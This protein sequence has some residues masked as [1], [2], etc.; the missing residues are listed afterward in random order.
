MVSIIIPIYNTKDYL[1]RCI[2]SVV[3]QSYSDIE[4]ILVNDGSTDNCL[5]ICEKWAKR[6][7]RIKII[8]QENRGVAEARNS[9]IKVAKGEYICFV[10]SDDYVNR[11]YIKRLYEVIIA[12]NI[13]IVCC[14]NLY[15]NINDQQIMKTSHR[16][17]G[18]NYDEVHTGREL[19]TML[20]EDKT[21]PVV[22]NKIYRKDI[23]LKNL[24]KQDELCVDCYF[25]ANILD[26]DTSI[27]YIDDVLYFFTVRE[28]AFEYRFH[29]DYY[30]KMIKYLCS[31]DNFLVDRFDEEI[32]ISL[33]TAQLR[34]ICYYLCRMPYKEIENRDEDYLYVLKELMK[35]KEYIT[36]NNNK[37]ILKAFLWVYLKSPWLAKFVL[38][39]IEDNKAK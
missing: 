12:N 19:L 15:V 25:L 9:G 20:L 18:F 10:D 17:H 32:I 30:L 6:D 28:N 4:I 7:N 1:E 33:R 16:I 38:S 14:G 34:Y 23:V 31:L 13:D 35:I 11:D 5:I 22:W 24:F 21:I 39:F 37:F 26:N 3:Q 8:N 27:M 2:R 29:K 36:L